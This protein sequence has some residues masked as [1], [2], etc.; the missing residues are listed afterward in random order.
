MNKEIE[1]KPIVLAQYR[2]LLL[3]NGDVKTEHD[4]IPGSVFKAGMD[5]VDPEHETTDL[6]AAILRFVESSFNTIHD[7]IGRLTKF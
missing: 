6:Y 7:D 2:V 5:A 3:P 1:S 4:L